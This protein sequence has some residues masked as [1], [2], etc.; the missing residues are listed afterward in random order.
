MKIDPSNLVVFGLAL[1]LL[2]PCI[3]GFVQISN[4][5][6]EPD[7]DSFPTSCDD[8]EFKCSRI[9]PNPHRS[10]GESELRFPST[11]IKTIS[12]SIESWVS[13]ESLVNEVSRSEGVDYGLHIVVKTKWMRYADDV[14]FHVSCDGDDVVV[15]IHSESRLGVGDLGV[16]GGRIEDIREH[17][18]STDFEEIEC[19]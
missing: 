15:W 9:A 14:F 13:D 7:Y 16:N 18:M 3:V 8:S 4:I 2:Y 12:E 5:V 10:T 17:L 6:S 1:I 19:S 11:S